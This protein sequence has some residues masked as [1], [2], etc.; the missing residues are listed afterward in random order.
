[1][2]IDT[3]QYSSAQRK[4]WFSGFIRY[5]LHVAKL[6]VH[7]EQTWWQ[8]SGPACF[9]AYRIR[10]RIRSSQVR[11]QLR[12]RILPFSHKSVER[13]E[14]LIQPFSCKK[15]NFNHQTYFSNSEPFKFHLLKHYVT[16]WE[17]CLVACLPANVPDP[18]HF[19]TDPDPWIRT[20][21]HGYSFRSY[22]FISGFRDANKK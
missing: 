20:M 11:I 8:C 4:V 3:A 13:T 7:A 9:R 5:R 2:N 12:L 10:V 1:M 19:K 18:W 21:D 15:F 22:P 17:H 16:D 14:I 6:G